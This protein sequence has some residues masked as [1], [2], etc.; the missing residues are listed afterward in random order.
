MYLII[1]K[2]GKLLVKSSGN[3]ND[4]MDYSEYADCIFIDKLVDEFLSGQETTVLNVKD[5]KKYIVK[6]IYEPI[7]IP[8]TTLEI[9]QEENTILKKQIQAMTENQTFLENCIIE[10]AQEIY[11]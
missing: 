9:V 8:K 6:M 5:N 4:M 7:I 1:E 10:L 3:I 2:S 11:K